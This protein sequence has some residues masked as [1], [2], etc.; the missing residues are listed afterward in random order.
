LNSLTIF[1]CSGFLPGRIASTLFALISIR[2]TISSTAFL[3]ERVQIPAPS[4]ISVFARPGPL[5]R[6]PI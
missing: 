5:R 4:S 2:A 1:G 3:S 6:L